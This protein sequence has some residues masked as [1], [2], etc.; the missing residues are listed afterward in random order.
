VRGVRN[1]VAKWRAPL[2]F[3]SP[4]QPLRVVLPHTPTPRSPSLTP[5]LNP[6][7]AASFLTL[8]DVYVTNF[9]QP[10][11]VVNLQ[12][13]FDTIERSGE[14]PTQPP[15]GNVVRTS[16]MA[17]SIVLTCQ[18]EFANTAVMRGAVVIAQ[19]GRIQN[20]V[21]DAVFA[22]LLSDIDRAVGNLERAG[23][24]SEP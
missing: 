10:H 23:L 1:T 18:E 2:P 3:I 7:A 16:R 4:P 21:N 6:A 22:K 13:S 19:D 9:R 15:G 14:A 17:V 8:G 20:P 12:S 24:R 11:K 5:P